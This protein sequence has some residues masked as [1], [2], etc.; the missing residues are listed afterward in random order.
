MLLCCWFPYSSVLTRFSEPFWKLPG[1]RCP[2]P[3]PSLFPPLEAPSNGIEINTERSPFHTN[4]HF[5]PELCITNLW[6]WEVLG[7]SQSWLRTLQTDLCKLHINSRIFEFAT[8]CP[9][10]QFICL[11][12]NILIITSVSIYG[13]VTSGNHQADSW[14]LL[15]HNNTI[16]LILL[17][18]AALPF[19]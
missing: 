6:F 9:K 5:I 14:G 11:L 13:E 7:Q 10:I 4:L 18:C 15:V 19:Q 2:C 12:V 3:A 17:Q 16:V 1:G 8:A